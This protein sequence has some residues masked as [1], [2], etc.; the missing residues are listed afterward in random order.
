M[1]TLFSRTDR[2]RI[3]ERV[4]ALDPSDEHL[5]GSM[6][7]SK[8]LCHVADALRMG[9]GDIPME[10][11]SG[12]LRYRP[13]ACAIIYLLPWPKGRVDGPQEAFTTM[14]VDFEEDRGAILDLIERM[15]GEDPAR[16]WPAHPAFGRLSGKDWGVLSHKHL[17]HHLRQFGR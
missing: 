16:A 4:R 9:L 5:W 15:G 12:P 2:A 17:D 10:K 6:P 1:R 14:P 8:M 13:A 3:C 11:P 7:I